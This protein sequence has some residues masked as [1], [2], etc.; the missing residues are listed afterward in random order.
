MNKSI[1]TINNE[2]AKVYLKNNPDKEIGVVLDELFNGINL[3][4][5][6]LQ[7]KVNF[8][9]YLDRQTFR[10]TPETY[11]LPLSL[12]DFIT[13]EKNNDG[14]WSIFS[15]ETYADFIEQ[16]KMV[17]ERA[18]KGL[19]EAII[20]VIRKNILRDIDRKQLEEVIEL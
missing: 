14:S 18:E 17:K 20:P 3:K 5:D 9:S 13:Y 15:W 19:I 7:D 16:L 11:E 2:V 8:T 12:P 1:E 6:K 10:L 4:V